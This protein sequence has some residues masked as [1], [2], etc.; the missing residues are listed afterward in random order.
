MASFDTWLA[1]RLRLAADKRDGSAGRTSDASRRQLLALA[2]RDTLRKRG[3]PSTWIAL[4][5][6][7]TASSVRA[8][9]MHMRLAV[10]EWDARFPAYMVALEK[11]IASAVRRMDPFSSNWLSGISWRFELADD[12][13]C[14]KLPHPETWLAAPPVLT[15]AIRAP[16]PLLADRDFAD[17]RPDF[18]PTQPMNEAALGARG[19]SASQ[20]TRAW[21]SEV[22]SS[23]LHSITRD[24]AATRP[25]VDAVYL[26]RSQNEPGTSGFIG[27]RCS[28]RWLVRI[29]RTVWMRLVPGFQYY[30]CLC[31]GAKIFRPRLRNRLGYGAVYIPPSPLPA[32]RERLLVTW[33]AIWPALRSR[34]RA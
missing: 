23:Y 2:L 10:R 17:A 3:M 11:E 18:A 29:R 5:A 16:K 33:P 28:A 1:S 31:C 26:G 14:P 24:F 8:R 34:Q 19:L 12:E 27:C 21:R 32:A 22:A 13:S 30:S 15:S 7:P 25:L 6:R 20:H 9:G 4:E